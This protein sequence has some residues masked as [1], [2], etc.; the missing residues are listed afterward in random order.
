MNAPKVNSFS[1]FLVFMI[2]S[3][4]TLYTEMSP[5]KIINTDFFPDDKEMHWCYESIIAG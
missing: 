5:T 4:R 3:V 1:L 2:V